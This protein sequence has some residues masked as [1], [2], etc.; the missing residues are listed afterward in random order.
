MKRYLPIILFFLLAIPFVLKANRIDSVILVLDT[1]VENHQFY[2][3]QKEKKLNTLKESLKTTFNDEQQYEI[4]GKLYDEYKKYKTDSALIYARKKL[5]LAIKLND[6][7]RITDARLNLAS[8]MGVIGLY[9]EAVSVIDQVNI[10]NNPELKAY[11]FHCYRTIYGFI[12][13][14]AVTNH[15]R[16]LYKSKINIL[17]DSLLLTNDPTSAPHIMVKTDRLIENGNYNEALKIAFD[18]FPTLTDQNEKAIIAYTISL[19][20]K[21]M[22]DLENEKYWL[23][24]SAINDLQSA[25]KEYISLRNLAFLLYQEG[26]IV[27]A[28]KYIIRALNDALFGNARLRTFEITQM[29]PIIENAYQSQMKSRQRLMISAIIITGSLLISLLILLV[30]LFRQILKINRISNDLNNSNIQL[31][32]VNQDLNLAV[33]ELK[34]ANNNLFEAN[35][36]TEEYIGR[37]M[38]L[39]SEYIDKLDSYRKRINRIAITGSQQE[40]I[41]ITKS[42]QLIED[43]LAEFY[44]NFDLTF[45]KIFPDFIEDFKKLIVDDEYI[46]TKPEQLM[47]TALRVYALIRLGITDSLKISHFLRCSLSTV[48]NYRTKMR[49]KAVNDRNSFEPEVMNIGKKMG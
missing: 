19:A 25:T 2:S 34:I 10:E 30:L 3:Q 39:C 22:N 38:D 32:R 49:N 41:Q 33:K 18:Y 16:E 23:T 44:H 7:Y 24:V 20:F 1:T 28:Y 40:I 35:V 4:F 46:Q 26:D 43:E 48:Y 47:N 27:R 42:K 14:Y 5:E 6:G 37:Y 36:I 12:G 13:D 11:Y 45:L 15:E 31:Q 8:I 17:R 21:G 29:L 9:A